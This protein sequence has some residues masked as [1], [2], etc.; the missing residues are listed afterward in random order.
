[1]TESGPSAIDAQIIFKF[2]NNESTPPF[3][4][5]RAP[6]LCHAPCAPVSPPGS[7]LEGN[8]SSPEYSKLN[9]RR[10]AGY[11]R[12]INLAASDVTGTTILRTDQSNWLLADT[13]WIFH[14]TFDSLL[15]NQVEQA[16]LNFPLFVFTVFGIV[17][18]RLAVIAYF[19]IVDFPHKNTFLTVCVRPLFVH[20]ADQRNPFTD[21][22]L[23]YPIVN[24]QLL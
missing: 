16:I 19:L 1:M 24:K 18:M 11:L 8:L 22:F 23:K 7:P 10:T 20:T 3:D 6:L 5:S 15:R 2:H 4:P 21:E 14:S 9:R 13:M 12:I 17:T